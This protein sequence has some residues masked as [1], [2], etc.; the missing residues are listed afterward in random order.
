MRVSRSGLL[1]IEQIEIEFRSCR[2][3]RDGSPEGKTRLV[4]LT[5]LLERDPEIVVRHAITPLYG[6][7]LFVEA[8]RLVVAVQRLERGGEAMVRLGIIRV[9][10]ERPLVKSDRLIMAS[11]RLKHGG[12]AVMRFG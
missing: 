4:E 3:E 6:N 7:R 11:Q 10:G 8:D 12:E 1:G 5:E 2:L 9:D